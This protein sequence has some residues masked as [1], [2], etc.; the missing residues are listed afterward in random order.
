[1]NGSS[2]CSMFIHNQNLFICIIRISGEKNDLK[3]EEKRAAKWEI[4]G[5]VSLSGW[6][7]LLRVHHGTS[8]NLFRW[9]FEKA[10]DNKKVKPNLHSW[11]LIFYATSFWSSLLFVLF[12]NFVRPLCSPCTHTSDDDDFTS[13][14]NKKMIWFAIAQRMND[15]VKGQKWKGKKYE[16]LNCLVTINIKFKI[17]RRVLTKSMKYK[18]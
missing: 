15:F 8:F 17:E 9:G 3:T 5:N 2:I 4:I 1:M 6:G 13:F 11:H 10:D 7:A 12:V 16:R 18:T 14:V